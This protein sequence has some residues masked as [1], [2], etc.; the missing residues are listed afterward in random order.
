MPRANYPAPQDNSRGRRELVRVKQ[1]WREIL[2]CV[3]VE[4]P[5]P[6]M[7]VI[8]NHWL[9]YQTIAC[10]I[11]ARSAFYQAGGAYGFRDQLQDVMALTIGAPN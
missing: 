1:Q 9:L 7:N 3:Q 10:R 11:H 4:T 8:L 5:D 6:Q 2:D